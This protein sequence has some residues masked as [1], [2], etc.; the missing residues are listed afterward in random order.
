MDTQKLD[1]T[2][3][4][5]WAE[6]LDR[7]LKARGKEVDRLVVRNTSLF[8][9]NERLQNRLKG[10][11]DKVEEKQQEVFRLEDEIAEL[12][13]VGEHEELMRLVEKSAKKFGS[14]CLKAKWHRLSTGWIRHGVSH[15]Y[16]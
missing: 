14:W 7:M 4:E 16:P 3:L 10:S 6:G 9:E 11:R 5:N 8:E 2:E 15:V 1:R 13:F 12:E